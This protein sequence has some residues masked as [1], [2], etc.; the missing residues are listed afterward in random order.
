[1]GLAVASANDYRW[2]LSTQQGVRPAAAYGT[3]VTPGNNTKGSWA[4]LIDGALVTEDVWFILVNL[5]SNAV[6]AAARDTLVDIGIDPSAG[7][8]YVVKIPNLLMAG[9]SRYN[10]GSG[11]VWYCFPLHIPAGSSIAARSSVNNATVGTHRCFAILLGAPRRPETTRKGTYIEAFGA[12]EASSRGTTVT[13]GTTSEGAWTQLGTASRALWWWQVGS[14]AND[15]SFQAAGIHLDV[16]AGTASDKKMLIED[17]LECRT[18]GEQQ[19]N[20]PLTIG[21]NSNCA[22]GDNI[23]GRAQSSAAADTTFSMMAYGVGG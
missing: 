2:Q 16:S 10:V 17:L 11:G 6:S 7:T 18:S 3:V 12:T 15:A 5:N 1:M 19:N 21:C 9:A 8:S 20:A 23:Y 14:A 22:P 4:E 13:P